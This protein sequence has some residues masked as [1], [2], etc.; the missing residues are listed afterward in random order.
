MHGPKFANL[1]ADHKELPMKPLATALPLIA[2]AACAAQPDYSPPEASGLISVRP[3]PGPD[4]VCQVL[5]EN[6]LTVEY[7]DHTA[8]LVGCPLSEAGAIKDR[9]REGGTIVD[10]AGEWVLISIPDGS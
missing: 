10:L 9:N 5:G 3:Y 4:D 1:R 8:T 7:L 6:A 2:L